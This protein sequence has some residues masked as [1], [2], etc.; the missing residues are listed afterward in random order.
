M[1]IFPDSFV[2]E[3]MNTVNL[4][5]PSAHASPLKAPYPDHREALAI[6]ALAARRPPG[7]TKTRLPQRCPPAG[8]QRMPLRAEP[9]LAALG[10]DLGSII[11]L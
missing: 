8:V 1:F 11:P 4:H 3:K 6:I 5:P 2:A 10:A 7:L 9:A